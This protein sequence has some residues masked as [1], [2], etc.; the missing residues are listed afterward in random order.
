M[1]TLTSYENNG[2]VSTCI[3]WAA[4]F[5]YGTDLF[6]VYSS[7]H[8]SK[9]DVIYINLWLL[10]IGLQVGL[11]EYT[12][13]ELGRFTTIFPHIRNTGGYASAP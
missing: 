13:I 6:N 3:G 5:V 10:L 2:T 8:R 1:R 7:C 9:C 11:Q 4:F 12:V